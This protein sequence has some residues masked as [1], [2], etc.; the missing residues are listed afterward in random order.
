MLSAGSRSAV[1]ADSWAR[2]NRKGFEKLF[3]AELRG[4]DLFTLVVIWDYNY[5]GLKIFQKWFVIL[6]LLQ[7]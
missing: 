1:L 6:C 2:P 5:I 4:K 7:S 3:Q